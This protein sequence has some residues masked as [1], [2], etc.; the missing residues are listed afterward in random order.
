ML[1]FIGTKTFKLSPEPSPLG[2]MIYRIICFP[3][4]LIKAIEVT[5]SIMNDLLRAPNNV[6]KSRDYSKWSKKY[7]THH[8]L[9]EITM[10]SI[11]QTVQKIFQSQIN[12]FI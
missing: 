3:I 10:Q 9:P 5:L 12:T 7:P 8:F 4:Y 11:K 6:F 2:K 1:L